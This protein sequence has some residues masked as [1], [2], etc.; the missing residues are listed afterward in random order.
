M[1]EES[2]VEKEHNTLEKFKPGCGGA[3]RARHGNVLIVLTLRRDE[4]LG[5]ER[6]RPSDGDGEDVYA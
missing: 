5:C 1:R 3:R 2:V 4:L 6:V